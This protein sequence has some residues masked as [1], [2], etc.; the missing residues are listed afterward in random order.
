MLKLQHTCCFTCCFSSGGET[1]TASW[2]SHGSWERI[3]YV[4]L[5]VCMCLHSLWL[6]AYVTQTQ[7]LQRIF[8]DILDIDTHTHTH[9]MS[10]PLAL[11]WNNKRRDRVPKQKA[12][13][14]GLTARATP[15]SR[16]AASLPGRD[17]DSSRH[18]LP[19]RLNDQELSDGS[20]T[21]NL[22]TAA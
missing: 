4:S 19:E 7:L 11:A 16:H 15:T 10:S 13:N 1:N 20:N 14:S 18:Q 9:T 21:E 8:P 5:Y 2:T 6:S 12:I 22:H 3:C 17:R